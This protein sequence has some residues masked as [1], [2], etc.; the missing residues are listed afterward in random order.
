MRNTIR[1]LRAEQ[2]LSQAQLAD[3]LGVSRQTINAVEN[4]RYEPSLPLAMRIAAVFHRRVEDIFLLDER[5][6]GSS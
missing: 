6:N 4:E 1:L 2:Q 3:M 5:E